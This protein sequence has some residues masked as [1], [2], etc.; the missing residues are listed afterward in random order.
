MASPSNILILA[1]ASPQRKRLLR[2]AGIRFRV[3]PS[4]IP[5]KEHGANGRTL[6]LQ[7]AKEKARAVAERH[8]GSWVLGADT[9][10]ACK[11]QLL[12]K[13]RDSRDALRILRVLNGSWQRVYTGVALVN[14]KAGKEYAGVA[15]SRVKARKMPEEWLR[16]YSHKHHD[17]AGAYSVQHVDDP[18]VERV[19]GPLDNVIGLPVDLVRRL[20]SRAGIC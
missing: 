5:E 14:R 9:T 12:A 1:S 2:E 6:A 8:P 10:V 17:K 13:P 3:D 15:M 7:L 11:G 4:G 19:D 18:F 16:R 20:L